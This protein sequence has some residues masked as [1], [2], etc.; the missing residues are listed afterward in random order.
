MAWAND[1]TLL[2]TFCSIYMVPIMI[3]CS[4]AVHINFR[5]IKRRKIPEKLKLK[6]D[7]RKYGLGKRLHSLSVVPWYMVPIMFNY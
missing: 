5:Y 7:K 3:N 4:G 6:V 1:F 2:A